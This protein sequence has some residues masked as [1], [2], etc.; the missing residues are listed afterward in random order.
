MESDLIFETRDAPNRSR[1]RVGVRVVNRRY[2]NRP[3]TRGA[4]V[5]AG[6]KFSVCGEACLGAAWNDADATGR[7][8]ICSHTLADLI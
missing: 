7:E 3:V 8:N 4:V 5:Y 6:G 1:F 2:H